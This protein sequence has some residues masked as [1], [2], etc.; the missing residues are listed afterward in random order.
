MGAIRR[1]AGLASPFNRA[2]V[3]MWAWHH[4][5]EITGWAG[6]VTRSAPRLLAGDTGDVLAEGRLRAKLTADSRTRDVSGLDVSVHD[7]VAHLK[8]V[9]D[10][11][12]ADAAR[13]IASATTGVRRVRDEM[14]T[15]KK[16]GRR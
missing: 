16:R 15:R 1:A 7:G 11:H 4:R 3:A 8:G 6:Y 9:L 10:E 5:G 13:E 14:T 2:A 12:V